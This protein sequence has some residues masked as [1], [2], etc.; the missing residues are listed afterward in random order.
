[1][2]DFVTT[3]TGYDASMR[4]TLHLASDF[5]VDMQIGVKTLKTS[6]PH[7]VAGHRCGMRIFGKTD[8]ER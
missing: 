6:T 3:L 4:S 5:G 7:F 2:A 1:M 8:K